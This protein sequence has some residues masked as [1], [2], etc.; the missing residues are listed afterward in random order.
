MKKTSLLTLILVLLGT[1]GAVELA[2]AQVQLQTP[3][4][5]ITQP[6]PPPPSSKMVFITSQAY[7]G[8][9]GGGGRRGF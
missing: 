2:W 7:T 3:Y 8:N 1:M 5:K 6:P 9:L 4:K